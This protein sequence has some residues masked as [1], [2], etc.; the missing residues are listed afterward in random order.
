M[1]IR[2]IVVEKQVQLLDESL[3]NLLKKQTKIQ[4]KFKSTFMA[5]TSFNGCHICK[6]K[7]HFATKCPKYTTTKPKCLKCG[8]LHR[9]KNCGLR[10]GFCGGLGHTEKRCWKKKDLKTSVTTTNY[11]EVVVDDEK[12]IENQLDK[13]C[14]SN[15]DLFSHIRVPRW[16]I[17]VEANIGE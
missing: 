7:N 15:H 1:I 6:A 3:I 16:R 4:T 13:I 5:S 9:T 14:G 8:G 17:H 2:E 11:L 12:V 10:C